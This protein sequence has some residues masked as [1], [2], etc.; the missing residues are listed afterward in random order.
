MS[1]NRITFEVECSKGTYVRTLCHDIGLKLG[2]GATMAALRRTAAEPFDESR[3]VPLENVTSVEDIAANLIQMDRAIDFVP[4]VYVSLEAATD[5]LHGQS[6][7]KEMLTG[8][9]PDAGSWVRMYDEDANFLAL[10]KI[11]Q[12]DSTIRAQPKRVLTEEMTD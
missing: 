2:C 9:V 3:A 12:R 11:V 7:P 1:G 10:G 4:A 8:D 6:V 5:V